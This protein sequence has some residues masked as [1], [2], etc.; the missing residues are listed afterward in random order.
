[1]DINHISVSR[2]D[3]WNKCQQQYKYKYHL[4]IDTGVEEPFYF[5]YGSIVHKI[6]ELYVEN[7]AEKT[8]EEISKSILNGDI[9]FDKDKDGNDV[10][11]P[12]LPKEY[13]KRFPKHIDSIQYL[14]D[15]L[16]TEGEIEYKF[17]FDIDPPNNK[18]IKGFIDRLIPKGDEWI[19]IDYKTTKK[20]RFR[21]NL[22]TIRNDLQLRAYARVV[23]LEKG[24]PA[25]KIRAALYYLEDKSLI[26][27]KFS[28]QSLIEAH[29]ELIYA[30]DQIKRTPEDKAWGNVQDHCKHCDY[31]TICPFYRLT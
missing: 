23:Q 24:I 28:E 29:E 13:K 1:M 11:A 15:Q 17:E 12:E 9:P 21:K 31:R 14:T 27:C 18:M 26:G 7:N 4:K 19:I 25:N 3:V 2:K 16:G 30:Y 6:A 8:L 22:R 20:G 5:T 10:F